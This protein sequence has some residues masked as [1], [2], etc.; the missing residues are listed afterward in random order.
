MLFTLMNNESGDS[1]PERLY[2]KYRDIMFYTANNILNDEFLAEDAV[3]QAFIQS[4]KYLNKIDENNCR[5]TRS[6]FVIICKNVSI[7]IY[8]Q[9]KNKAEYELNEYIMPSAEV[10]EEI[11]INN[12]SIEKLTSIIEKLN[13]IYSEVIFLKYDQDFSVNEIAEMKN[14]KPDTVQKRIERARKHL[15]ILLSKEE[16]QNG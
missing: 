7:N 10:P 15:L 14:I 6:F 16:K 2:K 9:R 8:N 12:E 5:K 1:K 13:P 4:H 3:H 11:I